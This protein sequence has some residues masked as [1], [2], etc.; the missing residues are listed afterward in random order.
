[1]NKD[2]L[3]LLTTSYPDSGDGSEAAGAFVRDLA[4]ELSRRVPVRVVAPGSREQCPSDH[5]DIAIWRFAGTGRPLSLLSP[6]S[7]G[8]WP[9]IARVLASMRRQAQAATVDGRVRHALALWVLPCGWI[10]RDRTRSSA[11][12]YSVWALGSDIWSLGRMPLVSRLLK[13][14]VADASTCFA[15]G[16]QLADDAAMLGGRPFEFLP[17]TRRPLLADR[18]PVGDAPPWRFLFLGRWHPNK[19]IDLLLDALRL[20]SEEAWSAIAEVTIA[21]GGPLEDAVRRSAADLEGAGRPIRLLGFLGTDEAAREIARAD[22]LL[23][24]SRIESIPVVLSDALKAGRPV[25]ATPV[26]DMTR[27]VGSHPACGIVTEAVTAASIAH[28]I[29]KATRAG[30]GRYLE[31]VGR[32]AST[33]DLGK[34]ADRILMAA[35][36]VTQ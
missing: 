2:S 26:G 18:R 34:I 4:E 30:P 11:T 17:S 6:K 21:G 14:V 32:T 19:G 1:M 20:L 27:I 36:M 3:L 9:Q 12:T 15:D 24:P 22:W 5:R 23:I 33:F 31:G 35:D 8:D 25:I 28:A 13:R 29:A 16:L 7:P 10:A